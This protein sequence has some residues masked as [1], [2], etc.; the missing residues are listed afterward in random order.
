LNLCKLN[1]VPIL[2]FS[3]I[4]LLVFQICF[5]NYCVKIISVAICGGS[6]AILTGLYPRRSITIQRTIPMSRIPCSLNDL[7]MGQQVRNQRGCA[8]A[9]CNDTNRQSH[10]G[11]PKSFRT[12]HNLAAVRDLWKAI[13]QWI[14]VITVLKCFQQDSVKYKIKYANVDAKISL[15]NGT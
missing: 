4:F 1:H 9:Q 10:S 6:F 13:G 12:A 2:I 14:L 7:Q 5:C 11:R 15:Q 8:C 3:H